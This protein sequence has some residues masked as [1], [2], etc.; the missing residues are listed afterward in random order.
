V[1]CRTLVVARNEGLIGLVT[2]DLERRGLEVY[3]A[4]SQAEAELFLRVFQFGL[5]LIDGE[6]ETSNASGLRPTVGRP[7]R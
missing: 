6:I 7:H 3:V 2:D 4:R 5:L 1:S